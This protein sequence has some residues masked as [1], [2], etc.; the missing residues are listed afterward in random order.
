M[1]IKKK[2]FDDDDHLEANRLLCLAIKED[3]RQK[4]K[5][6]LLRKSQYEKQL[7]LTKQDALKETPLHLAARHSQCDLVGDILNC[8][9]KQMMWTIMNRTNIYGRSP[10][11]E[12]TLNQKDEFVLS[13]LAHFQLTKINSK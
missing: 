12:S 8:L 5:N 10:L 4:V 1:S 3:I 6:I 11:H 9:P 7:L 2:F 13:K